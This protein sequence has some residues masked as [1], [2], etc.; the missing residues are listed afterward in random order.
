[1]PKIAALA[2]GLFSSIR[3]RVIL[4]VLYV[5]HIETER[6]SR[7]LLQVSSTF[8]RILQLLCR[9]FLYG[10]VGV[11]RTGRFVIQWLVKRISYL[12][13]HCQL[14][15]KYLLRTDAGRSQSTLLRFEMD[16]DAAL[17]L[18]RTLVRFLR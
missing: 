5:L 14:N 17:A 6:P 11:R 12:T 4:F 8:V 7:I 3:K 15:S 16:T 13:F 18:R 1:M 10:D 9:A 2:T